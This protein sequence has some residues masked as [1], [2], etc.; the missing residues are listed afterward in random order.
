MPAFDVIVIKDKLVGK[1][2]IGVMLAR[3]S[4]NKLIIEY[5]NRIVILSSPLAFPGYITYA[6][7]IDLDT[8]IEIV[9]TAEKFEVPIISYHGHQGTLDVVNSLTGLKLTAN[10]G[11]YTPEEGD[12]VI[13]IKLRRRLE[14]PEDV[15]QVKK[16]DVEVI[17][18]QYVKINNVM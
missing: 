17:L 7:R 11:I 1:H 4:L 14:K 3:E 6:E 5:A 12:V 15:K 13:A 2:N 9:R 8:L 18:L 16:D 10:R